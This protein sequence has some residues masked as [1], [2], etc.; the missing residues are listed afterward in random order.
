MFEIEVKTKES[1]TVLYFVISVDRR[2]ANFDRDVWKRDAPIHTGRTR[3]LLGG[4]NFVEVFAAR[5]RVQIRN[6]E[7]SFRVCLREHS[8]EMQVL[9]R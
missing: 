4:R 2:D 5:P 8:G 1:F 6:V 9:S 7:L 3:L